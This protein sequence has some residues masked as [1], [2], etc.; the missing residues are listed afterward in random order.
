MHYFQMGEKLQVYMIAVGKDFNFSSFFVI[1]DTLKFKFSS[2]VKA[3]DISF[4]IHYVFN[5][6]YSKEAEHVWRFF[7]KYFFQITHKNDK[8]TTALLTLL[9]ELRK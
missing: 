9:T 1:V 8:N 3:I 6:E 2:L 5:I 7:Q 4:K